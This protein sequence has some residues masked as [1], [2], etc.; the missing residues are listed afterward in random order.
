MKYL[1]FPVL[2]LTGLLSVIIVQAQTAEEIIEK[3]IDAMGGKDLL[4]QA[5]SLSIEGTTQVMG[6]DVPFNTTIL[7]GVGFRSETDFNGSKIIQVYTNQSG[8]TINP[9]AGAADAL[10]MPEDLYKAGKNQIFIA[11]ELS[12]HIEQGN[13]V[14]LIG[15]DGDLYKLK[16]TSP[17][18]IETNYYVDPSTYFVI[19]II[20]KG[21]MQGQEVE[22]TISYSNFKKTDFGL[23]MPFTTATD[24]GNFSM[25][26]N[27]NKI[28]FNT[29]VDP[30]IFE[31]PK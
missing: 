25:A 16:L 17:G 7:N 27:S 30:S 28:E 4:S 19:K 14:E 31:R 15:K 13:A 1:R 9:M 23:V 10:I 20:K 29:N 6:N 11:D 22:I 3:H 24:F 18:N 8:W 21:M 12:N 2:I 26:S 5:R